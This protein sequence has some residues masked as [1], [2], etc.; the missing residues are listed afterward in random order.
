MCGKGVP[1]QSVR[2]ES[3]SEHLAAAPLVFTARRT[4]VFQPIRPHRC[5][6]GSDA[7]ASRMIRLFTTDTSRAISPS[8]SRLQAF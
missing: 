5:F 2:A 7:R 1:S 3:S 6:D 8:E 4:E